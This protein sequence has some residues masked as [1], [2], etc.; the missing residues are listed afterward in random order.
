[1]GAAVKKNTTIE[2]GITGLTMIT[3]AYTAGIETI[4]VTTKANG[5]S[6]TLKAY[7]NDVQIGSSKSLSSTSTE[8]TFTLDSVSAGEIKL[9]WSQTSSAKYI[10]VESIVIN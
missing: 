2:R 8:Y 10:V 7:L 9:V 3:S 4:K 6:P 5:T 1:M